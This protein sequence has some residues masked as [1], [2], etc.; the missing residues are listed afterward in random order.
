MVIGTCPRRERSQANPCRCLGAG[1]D[2][3]TAR[4]KH[5][6]GHRTKDGT[7]RVG[8]KPEPMTTRMAHQRFRV[9]VPPRVRHSRPPV[10]G[11]HW[12][13]QLLGLSA[14]RGSAVT[15]AARVNNRVPLSH[16]QP[17]LRDR[18]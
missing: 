2:A 15:P 18:P 4:R 5:R 10:L 8:Q 12:L 14:P 1:G 16:C 13:V 9:D 3:P 17:H 6:P 7:G 11:W